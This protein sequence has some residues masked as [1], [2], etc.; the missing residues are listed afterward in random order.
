MANERKK[1]QKERAQEIPSEVT[2]N[3][4]MQNDATQTTTGGGAASI[5][6]PKEQDLSGRPFDVDKWSD[7]KISGLYGTGADPGDMENTMLWDNNLSEE[8]N[9][10]RFRRL[11]ARR[12][13]YEAN[14]DKTEVG[15]M[16]FDVDE[17]DDKRVSGSLCIWRRSW[18]DRERH[19]RHNLSDEENEERFRRLRERRD[20]LDQ[21]DFVDPYLVEA[22]RIPAMA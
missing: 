8:E 12:D 11:R 14:P 6:E 15:K 3:P 13:A 10:E 7:M 21:E 19:L 2:Y 1:T 9:D 18:R 17:W 22:V 20:R 5:P 4:L 16:K